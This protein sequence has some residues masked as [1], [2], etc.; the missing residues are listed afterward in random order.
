[1]II[2]EVDQREVD[3]IKKTISTAGVLQFRIVANQRRHQVLID[4]ATA[5][6][7]DPVA[8]RGRIIRDENRQPVALWARVGREQK[9]IR[10]VRPFRLDVSGYTVRNATTGD[11]VAIPPTA[12]TGRDDD[13]RR[14]QL[15][16]YTEKEG[17]PELDVLM[18]TDDGFD[19]NGSH[20]GTVAR[21][22]DEVMNP[23]IHFNL[24]GRGVSLFSDLTG[25]FSPEGQFH[26]QLGIVLDNELLSA[27]NIQERITGQGRI[28]G[29][30]T[31]EEVDFLVNIL[32]AGSLPVVL[33]KTPIAEDLI[34][35]LLGRETVERSQIAMGISLL[36]VFAVVCAY[37]RFSGIVASVAMLTN[38]LFILALMVLI[39]A[40]LTLP[41]IAG[42]VLTV[43]MSIDANVLI[44]ERMREEMAKGSTL[45]MAIRN[46]FARATVTI[47]DSNLTTIITAI[48]LYLIG[49]DQIRGFAV[50]LILGILAS[51]FTAIF[52]ARVVFDIAERTRVLSRLKMMQFFATPNYDFL[53]K[54]HICVAA[55]IALITI[56]LIGVVARGR[57]LFDIDF[58]GGTSVHLMLSEPTETSVVREI[59]DRK[60]G[61]INKPE[62]VLCGSGG[63]VKLSDFGCA[64]VMRRVG[65]APPPLSLARA[66]SS[67]ASSSADSGG[68]DNNP[69][70]ADDPSLDDVFDRCDGTPAFLAP[71]VAL[72]VPGGGGGG[73][74]GAAAAAADS[75]QQGQQQQ[76]QQG[77]SGAGDATASSSS[78][79]SNHRRVRY[80]GRPADVWSLGACLY[81]LAFGRIPFSAASVPALF[82][83]V[84]AEPLRF[85]PDAAVSPLL[86][87][88][89]CRMM[90]KDAGLRLTLRGAAAHPWTRGGSAGGR[91]SL[92]ESVPR[93][94][95]GPA[96][97]LASL[98]PGT[99]PRVDR[100]AL[101]LVTPDSRIVEFADGD[102]MLRAGAPGTHAL[103]VLRGTA[104]VWQRPGLGLQLAHQRAR[105]IRRQRTRGAA[106][107]RRSTAPTPRRCCPLTA[108]AAAAAGPP[109]LPPP[110]RR[111]SPSPFPRSRPSTRPP[112][113]LCPPPRWPGRGGRGR[114]PSPWREEATAAAEP[115]TVGLEGGPPTAASLLLQH[116]TATTP[117]RS[118]PRE[119]SSARRPRSPRRAGAA[120]RSSP[121]GR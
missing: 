29:N 31:Q 90:C 12:I 117:S 35:P 7:K 5:M 41:G 80:R 106:P 68:G 19:V 47:I 103:F 57:G 11:L 15:A 46:G 33:N 92:G 73:G 4:L 96:S 17:I 21:G 9:V 76:Q 87:D 63:S 14:L 104:E 50:T 113:P 81:T 89:L 91:L 39:K 98:A 86:K 120:P 77:P 72:G 8:K 51:M 32:Q 107:C 16:Q 56:G 79:S 10:G 27:P 121:G 93:S 85:P 20:L 49:T 119:P 55:S 69:L 6:A 100:L 83:V 115:A 102:E 95:P 105:A 74:T 42:L 52:C 116:P 43:G 2:P 84:R 114:S 30:F 58:N 109:P 75:Q 65:G 99:P 60:F 34:N 1:M 118:A 36:L 67:P 53:G 45:R 82:R 62:N 54:R 88:L 61:E 13:E 78:C 70:H 26:H 111:R 59:L 44:Y 110:P 94:P 112:S 97:P 66:S 37:Y 40:A 64:K 48:V 22:Y 108:A 3:Q 71:E 25:E 23:A 28:T 101:E 18:A 24:K 38:L